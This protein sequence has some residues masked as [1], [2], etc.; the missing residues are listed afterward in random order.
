LR[1]AVIDSQ[2][3]DQRQGWQGIMVVVGDFPGWSSLRQR[4]GGREATRAAAGTT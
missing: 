3:R 4:D 2:L 1:L